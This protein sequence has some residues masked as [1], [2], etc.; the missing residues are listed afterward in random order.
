MSIL[1]ACITINRQAGE[2][3]PRHSPGYLSSARERMIYRRRLKSMLASARLLPFDRLGNPWSAAVI[4]LW[5]QNYLGDF[6]SDPSGQFYLLLAIV[7]NSAAS[8]G[9]FLSRSEI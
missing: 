3:F 7:W 6:L 4:T 5:N 1:L 8:F 2:T 9:Y